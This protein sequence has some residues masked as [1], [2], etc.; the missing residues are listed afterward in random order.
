MPR[1]KKIAKRKMEN[2]ERRRRK[3]NQVKSSELTGVK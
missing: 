2:T 1:N 3:N